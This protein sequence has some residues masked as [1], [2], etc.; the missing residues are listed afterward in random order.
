MS[1]KPKKINQRKSEVIGRARNRIVDTDNKLSVTS[2]KLEG[3][4]QKNLEWE[5]LFSGPIMEKFGEDLKYELSRHLSVIAAEKI[6]EMLTE[7]P[8]LARIF[9]YEGLDKFVR[10]VGDNM[11]A[12]VRDKIF[13][14]AR[15]NISVSN[16]AFLR[17]QIITQITVPQFTFAAVVSAS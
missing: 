16:D 4:K 11:A 3:E 1:F 9:I 10:D 15:S 8:D 17:Q 2:R 13:P 6:N 14:N 12:V 7:N 5:Q